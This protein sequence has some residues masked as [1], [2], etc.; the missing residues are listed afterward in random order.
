[1]ARTFREVVKAHSADPRCRACHELVDPLGFPFDR[2][3]SIG[4]Y[5]DRDEAGQLI[6][7]VGHLDGE[8]FDGVKEL[9]QRLV[10]TDRVGTC[11]VKHWFRY[12]FGR[13][14]TEADRCVLTDLEERLRRSR[15]NVRELLLDIVTSVPF[16]HTGATP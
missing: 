15:G 12:A 14:E 11:L 3:D 10:A 13:G 9:A 7:V 4:Q 6:D 1:M 8:R 5:R 2:Y 16:R